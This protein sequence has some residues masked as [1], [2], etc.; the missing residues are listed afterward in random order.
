MNMDS[1]N[2]NG[3]PFHTRIGIVS[4]S[5]ASR[6]GAKILTLRNTKQQN[7]RALAAR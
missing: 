5:S 2:F 7:Q 4:L 1:G 6:S 3:I